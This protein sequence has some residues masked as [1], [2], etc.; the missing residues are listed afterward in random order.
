M[1]SNKRASPAFIIPANFYIR[2]F[3]EL[4]IYNKIKYIYIRIYSSS[5]EKLLVERFS[6]SYKI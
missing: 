6:K 1:S 2:I 4:I 3:I 5:T